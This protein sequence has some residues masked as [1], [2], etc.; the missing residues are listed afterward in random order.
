MQK[1]VVDSDIIVDHLRNANFTLEHILEMVKQKK[2]RAL[3][4]S[5]VSAE[6]HSGQETKKESKLKI[7]EDLMSKLEFVEDSKEIAI[8][9]GFLLRDYRPIKLGDAF[10]AATALNLNAK[11]ASR[12]KKDF[13][14]IKGLKFFKFRY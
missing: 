13:G 11:L 14:D 10:I 6:I 3:L 12:N 7:I 9:A 5:V 1:I 8:L 4:P 2:A